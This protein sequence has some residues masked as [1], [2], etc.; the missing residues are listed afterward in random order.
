MPLPAST[1]YRAWAGGFAYWLAEPDT[2]RMT[3]RVGE[4][5]FFEAVQR[6]AAGT[7]VARHPHYGRFQELAPDARVRLSW[8]TRGTGVDTQITVTFQ[9]DGDGTLV[10]LVHEGFAT[11]E[12]RHNHLN[13]WPQVL[14]VQEQR[15]LALGA[16]GIPVDTLE[17]IRA[18]PPATFVPVRSYPDLTIARR[19]L[20]DVLSATE[21][22]PESGGR[23]P[24]ALGTG[25][26]MAA[27]WRAEAQ[28]AG[29][30]PPATLMVRVADVD[31]VWARALA[32]GATPVA[33]PADQPEGER[34]AVLKD[35]AGHSWTLTQPR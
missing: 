27:E 1:L 23:V 17:P 34:Q 6:D 31:A 25:A 4:P 28:P 2:I 5:F 35:P 7:I 19:F 11:E 14:A 26:M 32:M 29:G 13:A 30:R 33:A 8:F 21:G 16:A 20:V 18:M 15:L 24:F 10:T 3:A 12:S 22:S 9:P